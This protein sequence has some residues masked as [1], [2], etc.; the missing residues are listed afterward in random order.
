PWSP[1]I[2]LGN[3][4]SYT[5]DFAGDAV[6]VADVSPIFSG[7]SFPN[8]ELS[9][10][11]SPVGVFAGSSVPSPPVPVVSEPIFY[12]SASRPST[13]LSP[14]SLHSAVDVNLFSANDAE[15]VLSDMHLVDFSAPSPSSVVAE[16][17]VSQRIGDSVRPDKS[18]SDS[19]TTA[20][21][22]AF[23]DV[24]TL[25][26]SEPVTFPNASFNLNL[27]DSQCLNNF[28]TTDIA[29][30]G[31]DLAATPM[32]SSPLKNAR[33]ALFVPAYSPNL[34]VSQE[35]K[36]QPPEEPINR[37]EKS[38]GLRLHGHPKPARTL[39]QLY[40]HGHGDTSPTRVEIQ[41]A[42][43]PCEDELFDPSFGH[44]H[45]LDFSITDGDASEMESSYNKQAKVDRG[46]SNFSLPRVFGSLVR[47]KHRSPA[48]VVPTVGQNADQLA[49]VSG[50]HPDES[51]EAKKKRRPKKSRSGP[52]RKTKRSTKDATIPPEIDKPNEVPLTPRTPLG[53]PKDL[54]SRQ[55][56]HGDDEFRRLSRDEIYNL[57]FGEP[58]QVPPTPTGFR[59]T[60]VL[61][62][63]GNIMDVRRRSTTDSAKRR[64]WS[65]VGLPPP[66]CKFVNDDYL[67]P[68]ALTPT[69]IPSFRGSREV[70]YNVPYMD[71]QALPLEEPEW[72]IG[73][74]RR[75]LLSQLS[76]TSEGMVH[77]AAEEESSIISLDDKENRFKDTSEKPSR[78]SLLFA[79]KSRSKSKKAD[80]SEPHEQ[81]ASH[82]RHSAKLA[83]KLN[84]AAQSGR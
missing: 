11:I 41:A 25:A 55:T 65:T 13:Y 22:E 82:S 47:R 40:K 19:P 4:N 20:I 2:K 7:L 33:D 38:W 62:D 29:D 26:S 58:P 45:P 81:S 51:V 76:Q 59:I 34:S 10:S 46:R 71:D 16:S 15:F 1:K 83:L 64:P 37:Q 21:S 60:P 28:V 18:L 42:T 50:A 27:P 12:D 9:S 53:K 72:P 44:I 5:V 30:N 68:D 35:L 63:P 84:R 48:D 8:S 3:G 54:Y 73:E 52:K 70:V 61:R 23:A 74:S 57:E 39:D 69:K 79:R 78:V 31:P 66:G 77:I 6:G 67:F 17:I 43:K 75:T 49:P 80:A 14:S 56:W 24:V 32:G 36:F